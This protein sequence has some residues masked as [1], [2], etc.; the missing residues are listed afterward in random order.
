M[1]VKPKIR[2]FICTTAH[3]VGCAHNVQRQIDYVLGHG[4]IKDGPKKV[5]VL[6]ASTGYGLASRIVAAFGSRA[7]TV[8]VFF[9]KEADGKRTA[10]A[11]YYN[12]VALE[13]KIL[14]EGLYTRSVNGDAFSDE[15]KQQVVEI[16]K[17]D[18]GP[19]DLVVYS[20]AAPRRVHPRT[21]KV[22]KSV[23]KPVGRGYTNKSIDMQNAALEEVTLPAA[24]EEEI[25]QTVAVMGGE[26]WHYWIDILEENGLLADG[27][28]TVAYSYIGPEVTQGVYRNGTIGRAKDHL[29]R[30][31]NELDARLKKINGRAL[32]SV[33]KAL[34]TQS[35]S[36][37]PFIPLY[38]VILSKVM[39]E[40]GLEEDTVMQIDRLFRD[41]LYSGEPPA[42]DE[43]GFIRLDDR[44]LRDD[45]QA[46]VNER[47]DQLTQETLSGLADLEGYQSDFLRLFGFGLPGVDY[48]ADVD[49]GRTLPSLKESP[50]S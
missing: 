6:G 39:K 2:G 49:V 27:V 40:K 45:V 11:G 48:D 9:E 32:I 14:A 5:L 43:A 31:A 4:P 26:D 37:I 23:L 25:E 17:R 50:A 3:P 36:A 41:F 21:G 42:T 18:V 15:V 20:V 10:T 35:S 8:G 44:E 1:I 7:E 38:F 47:W 24:T 12:S 13:E 19:V 28:T 30:T 29:E 46:I 16:L 33:N 22:S 34:V